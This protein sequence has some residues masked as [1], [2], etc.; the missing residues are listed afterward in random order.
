MYEL[1]RCLG[2]LGLGPRRKLGLHQIAGDQDRPHASA[3]R[4][5]H[6]GRDQTLF[7]RHQPHDGA[8]LAVVTKRADDRLNLAPHPRGWK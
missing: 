1:N 4:S 7:R 6:I 8:M 3:A 2:Q 5:P